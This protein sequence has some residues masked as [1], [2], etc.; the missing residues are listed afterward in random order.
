MH[1]NLLNPLE[2]RDEKKP[3]CE[4]KVYVTPALM[5]VSNCT[6]ETGA[7]TDQRETHNGVWI[8]AS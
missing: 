8:L 5:I 1:P 2:N 3:C 4:R 6:P 7:A